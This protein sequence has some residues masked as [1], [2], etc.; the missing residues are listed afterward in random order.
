MDGMPAMGSH[1]RGDTNAQGAAQWF[2]PWR[3]SWEQKK[4][5]RMRII[6][7][8]ALGHYGADSSCAFD[9]RPPHCEG[10]G[11]DQFEIGRRAELL[12]EQ[13]LEPI[14]DKQREWLRDYWGAR[15]DREIRG[16]KV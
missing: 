10:C 5:E 4:G 13:E 9:R 12:K 11:W 15:V 7:N 3:K 14:S 1:G 2:T 16:L 8:C 6:P